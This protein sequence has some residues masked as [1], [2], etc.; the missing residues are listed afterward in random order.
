MNI[1]QAIVL[2]IVQGLTEFI[3]VSSS[4]HLV[5]VPHFFGWNTPPI[6]FDIILHLGTL[7]AILIFF[8]KDILR[9]FTSDRRYIFLII[10]AC[11]PT[12]IMG[13]LFKDF[14]ES[15]F[16]NPFGVSILLLVTGFILWISPSK[17]DNA[18]PATEDLAGKR[19]TISFVDAIWIG[20]AQ[21]C[22]IA[23][24]ISRSGA[25][26]VTGLFRGLSGEMAVRF[27][28]LLSIPAILGALVF[29]I[30]D[31]QLQSSLINQA[32]TYLLGGIAAAISGYLAIKV[33]FKTIKTGKFK[34]FAIYCW[35]LGTIGLLVALH[36]KK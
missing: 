28:F 25:T 6:I 19:T 31:F 29:K 18:R 1:I 21:G 34:Y 33:V 12:G 3:P 17:R 22:A 13:F 26:I 20:F 2:G 4:A 16:E 27:S 23:P 30:K 7:V 36:F 10:I 11:I 9:L 14:F 35:I 24:G 15:L 32:T 8:W 5:L